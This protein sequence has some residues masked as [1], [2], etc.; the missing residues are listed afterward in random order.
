MCFKIFLEEEN[1]IILK[2]SLYRIEIMQNN[3]KR[4]FRLVKTYVGLIIVFCCS[5]ML[6]CLFPNKWIDEN[7]NNSIGIIEKEGMGYAPFLNV[8]SVQLDSTTDTLMYKSKR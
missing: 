8:T 1:L 4:M 3:K 6:V 5:L 2:F 7:V